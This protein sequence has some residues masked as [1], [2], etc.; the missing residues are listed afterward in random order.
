[1]VESRAQRNRGH[2]VLWCAVF[3]AKNKFISKA[4]I[5]FCFFF[6]FLFGPYPRPI[7]TIHTYLQNGR[8]QYSFFL[9]VF[10]L[11]C[12]TRLVV[13]SLATT[14]TNA[15]PVSFPCFNLKKIIIIMFTWMSVR[16][17]CVEDTKALVV[18]CNE[19]DEHNTILYLYLIIW[20]S[21]FCTC[22]AAF[23]LGSNTHASH[24]TLPP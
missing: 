12:L 19:A 14:Q 16:Y 8:H 3:W 11:K 7:H 24:F 4:F 18:Y 2:F 23:Y 13:G 17:E 21:L 10:F 1:M 9:N 20:I 5:L 22:Y 6:P 15:M